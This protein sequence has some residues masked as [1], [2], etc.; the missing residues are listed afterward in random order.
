[1]STMSDTV[2]E[3]SEA[4]SKQKQEVEEKQKENDDHFGESFPSEVWK[5]VTVRGIDVD[6]IG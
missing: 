2:G 1:M 3:K 6:V 4:S 5:K